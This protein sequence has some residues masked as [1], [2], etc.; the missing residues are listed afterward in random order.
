M[1]AYQGKVLKDLYDTLNQNALKKPTGGSPEIE[2]VGI[3]DNG[4]QVM[5]QI[6]AIVGAN[7]DNPVKSSA[8]AY[9]IENAETRLNSTIVGVRDRVITLENRM[10]GLPTYSL[11]GTTLTITL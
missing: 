3:D 1:S 7:S 8:V 6:D 9:A 10:N 4:D 2:L 11:D 5:H